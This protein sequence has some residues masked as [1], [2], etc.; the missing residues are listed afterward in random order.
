MYIVTGATGFI[1]SNLLAEMQ[2]IGCRDIVAVDSFGC[3]AKWKNVAM[4]GALRFVFPEQLPEFLAAHRA[5][6]NAVFHLGAISS[7]TETDV[8]KIVANNFQLTLSLYEFCRSNG[9]RMV[10][11]SSAATYGAGEQGFVDNDS[12]EFISRL[13]PLNP[14]GWSKNAVD[15]YI[16]ADSCFD[17]DGA[18][19][20][21]LKFFN[22]YGPNEY[23]K[24]MQMS[25]VRHFYEQYRTTGKVRLFK[26]YR[27]DCAHG[28]QRRDFVWVGDCVDVMLWMMEHKE[29]KGLFNVGTGHATTYNIVARSVA[30]SMGVEPVIEYIEMPDSVKNQYQYFTEADLTKLRRA[31]YTASMTSVPDGVELY[32]KGFLSQANCYR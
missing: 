8:D 16:A 29:V 9:I 19:M 24:G 21:G 32:V 20:V 7:T 15:K 23:H 28:E 31:G 4:R 14:Y 10:Y 27:D 18:G 12:L 6:I 26:S 5:E 2:N 22:V 30:E 25:V 3:D 1:G 11:A 17:K 13:R